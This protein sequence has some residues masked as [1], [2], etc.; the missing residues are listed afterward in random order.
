MAIEDVGAGTIPTYHATESVAEAKEI[1]E[2]SKAYVDLTDKRVFLSGPMS[3]L[4]DYNRDAFV[5]A[6][7]KCYGAGA[8]FV[9]NPATHWGHS[10]QP[11]EWYMRHDI[12]WLTVSGIGGVPAF[13]IVVQLSGWGGSDGARIEAEVARACGIP[14]ASI[15]DVG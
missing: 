11:R 9:F 3:G 4:P 12:N 15:E 2:L 13:N 5:A 1:V 10:D 14:L 8:S 7:S 6:E